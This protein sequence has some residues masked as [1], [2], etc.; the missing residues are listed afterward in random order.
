MATVNTKRRA[1]FMLIYS[2]NR[3]RFLS[4]LSDFVWWLYTHQ[5][6]LKS[7]YLQIAIFLY[8]WYKVAFITNYIKLI[9]SFFFYISTEFLK[10]VAFYWLTGLIKELRVYLIDYMIVKSFIYFIT[11]TDFIIFIIIII[12]FLSHNHIIFLERNG[13]YN[14]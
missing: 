9:T 8:N 11:M 12:I 1:N 2:Y 5:R 14:L 4:D 6:L 3:T 7:Y 13:T 10:Y